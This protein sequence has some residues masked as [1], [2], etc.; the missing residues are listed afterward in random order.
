M[1][2]RFLLHIWVQADCRPISQQICKRNS[3]NWIR[4][5]TECDEYVEDQLNVASKNIA[6]YPF[7]YKDG[8]QIFGRYF[9]H[10]GLVW[11]KS[12]FELFFSAWSDCRTCQISYLSDPPFAFFVND[13][14][15]IWQNIWNQIFILKFR[16]F[17]TI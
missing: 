2:F 6:K 7:D 9:L 5:K 10:E 1:H 4:K 8:E 11:Q 15:N 14:A 13:F 16:Q 17:R 3:S 12:Y